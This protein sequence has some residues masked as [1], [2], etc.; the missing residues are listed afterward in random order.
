[1]SMIPE[2]MSK[3]QVKRWSAFLLLLLFACFLI[4][5]L[6]S[7]ISPFLGALIFAILFNGFMEKLVKKG[8]K[9]SFAA[10]LIILLSF[11]II[12]IPILS[13]SYMLYSKIVET[14][15]DP[16]SV[17]SAFKI[18]D[19]KIFS[20]SGIRVLSAETLD[21]MKM[22]AGKLI[23]SFASEIFYTLGNIGIMYFILYYLLI[24]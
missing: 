7:F 2:S 8:W 18:L 19:E 24:M 14:I 17:F 15:V 6:R 23:T 20:I 1:M 4:Y 10:I 16:D 3:E 9:P 12:L 5:L 22:Q 21:N 13:L 11:I